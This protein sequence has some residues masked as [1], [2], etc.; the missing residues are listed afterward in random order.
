MKRRRSAFL[1]AASTALRRHYVVKK[2]D[3]TANTVTI[4]PD[5]AET[6]D[7]A[8]TRVITT[9]FE[10]VWFVSNGTAWFVL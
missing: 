2:T 9:Q 7:G 4:N 3:A 1:P 8:S 5:G 10:S 6:I